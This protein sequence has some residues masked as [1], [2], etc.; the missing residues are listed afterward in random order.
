MLV[1]VFVQTVGDVE[2]NTCQNKGR[3]VKVN[4]SDIFNATEVL[5]LATR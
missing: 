5:R 2:G 4:G 1:L 3:A